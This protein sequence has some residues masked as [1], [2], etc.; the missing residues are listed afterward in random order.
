VGPISAS[1][2]GTYGSG[3]P[4]LVRKLIDSLVKRR[5]ASTRRTGGAGGMSRPLALLTTRG[6]QS[7]LDRS[8]VINGIADGDETW[9]VVASNGGSAHHPAWFRNMVR[10]PDAIWL[11]VGGRKMRVQ[12]ESLMGKERDEA[13]NRIA[14][15]IQ[16][17]AGY[18]KKTDRVIP[19]VRLTRVS[20]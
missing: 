6:A 20:E 1:P 13:Y 7:G 3:T 4:A 2:E 11:E 18:P 19:V 10:H 15:M 16:L 8:V 12:G 5:I 14:K 9:L 17:Y